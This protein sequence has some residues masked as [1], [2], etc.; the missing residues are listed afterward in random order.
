MSQPWD[1]LSKELLKEEEAV[2][3]KVIVGMMHHERGNAKVRECLA[4][5]LGPGILRVKISEPKSD[6][7]RFY[8]CCS[9]RVDDMEAKAH[10]M[11]RGKFSLLRLRFLP[12]EIC[13]RKIREEDF[14]ETTEK[15]VSKALE[16]MN[17]DKQLA[18]TKLQEENEKRKAQIDSNMAK[19]RALEE[20][21]LDI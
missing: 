9:F 19:K 10:I 12:D 8:D 18:E 1:A 3:N 6:A 11:E 14:Q 4:S 5:M 13:E 17:S 20:D 21:C 2:D 7:D 16:K 15:K